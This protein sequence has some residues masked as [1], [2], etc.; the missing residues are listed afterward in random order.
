MSVC[1]EYLYSRCKAGPVQC[2]MNYNILDYLQCDSSIP[3]TSLKL[4]PVEKTKSL[5][6][7]CPI[8]PST[9]S[10][11]AMLSQVETHSFRADRMTY[12]QVRLLFLETC[13]V[14]VKISDPRKQR[15][16]LGLEKGH[17]YAFSLNLLPKAHFPKPRKWLINVE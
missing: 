14:K 7:F 8:A 1:T 2:R 17:R 9:H 15:K 16:G 12:Y 4:P 10:D 11:G 5:S 13:L 3:P 6:R